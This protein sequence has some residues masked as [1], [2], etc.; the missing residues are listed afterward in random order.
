MNLSQ[1]QKAVIKAWIIANNDS[2]FDQSAVDLLN[3]P[4]APA[5][6]VYR[7]FVPT[8]EIMGNNFD[9]TRV[10]NLSAGKARIWEWMKEA[11]AQSTPGLNFANTA[12]RGGINTVWVGTQADLNVRAAVY[13]HATR[14]ATVAEKLL[15]SAGNGTAPDAT[16]DGPA[17]C[18]AGAEGP[19]DLATVIASESA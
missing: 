13:T 2:I 6:K 4:A 16:G 19:I 10:D 9:W 1:P 3:A 18:G 8:Q 11:Y 7:S 15:K 14:D 12:C 17:T 5:Y